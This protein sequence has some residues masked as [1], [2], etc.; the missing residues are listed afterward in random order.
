MVYIKYGCCFLGLLAISMI[1]ACD[2]SS[3]TEASNPA[4]SPTNPAVAPANLESKLALDLENVVG[5]IDGLC[6][7][8]NDPLI[9]EAPFRRFGGN[10]T[11]GYNWEINSSNA[12]I[13]HEHV[14]D[15]WLNEGVG[16]PEKDSSPA[17]VILK[18]V[19]RN[20]A[21]GAESLVT[22]PMAGYVA[23]DASKKSVG[24]GETAPSK[25]WV[26][27]EPTK[28]G[29]GFGAPDLRDGKVYVD[30][31][32]AWFVSKFGASSQGG[33]KYYS[34]DNEPSIWKDTHPRLHSKKASYEE[35][36]NKSIVTADAVL[37]VDPEAQIVGA[38]LYGWYGHVGLQDAPDKDRFNKKHGNFSAYYLSTMRE[39]SEKRGKRLLHMFDF[40]WYPEAT[41]GGKRISIGD[42]QN[43]VTDVVVEARVQAPR[44]LWDPSY[45]ENSWIAQKSGDQPI[46]LIPRMQK[47]IEENYPGTRLAIL[48][49]NYGAG[50]H[51]SGGLATA[52][53]LG[54]FGRYGVAA[55]LWTVREDNEFEKAAFR[56]YLNY[57]GEG[58]K[59]EKNVI[60]VPSTA[61]Q[62]ESIYAACSDDKKT[63]TVVLIN[64][65]PGSV[66]DKQVQLQGV[67][68]V[69][70]VRAFR[71]GPGYS[72]LRPVSKDLNPSE[73]GFEIKCP[74][75]TATLVE[76]K[77]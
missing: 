50:H 51:F 22:V 17:A 15:R 36:T 41:G 47:I 3:T 69:P 11:T 58:S 4:V 67:Q 35:V 57:D 24:W 44:S 26:K 59:F 66:L 75:H 65:Q 30:E 53:V 19:E 12:G 55:C 8:V 72:E 21:D 76:L 20:Q 40:H 25:R 7:G 28:P 31:E 74:P 52:D 64:K 2:K 29:G 62:Q 9:P 32:V 13:D 49:Y 18:T 71:F 37:T 42:G 34:L 73:G 61:S 14:S 16:L 1:C 54:I 39:A 70:A 33:I 10:R 68:G 77:L 45:V 63:L 23:A 38:A 43:V 5:T 46:Q 6:Y 27:L 56:L 60:G 48:E